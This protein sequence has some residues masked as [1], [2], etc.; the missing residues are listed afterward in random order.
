MMNR[1]SFFGFFPAAVAGAVFGV[2]AVK[3]AWGDGIAASEFWRGVRRY[4]DAISAPQAFFKGRPLSVAE[5]EEFAR[6]FIHSRK[7]LADSPALGNYIDSR[8]RIDLER[9]AKVQAK[10]AE[11][12][13]RAIVA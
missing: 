10:L 3:A 7:I 2:P 4:C 13:G 5:R 9:L 11:Y 12:P 6:R 1:R 8:L